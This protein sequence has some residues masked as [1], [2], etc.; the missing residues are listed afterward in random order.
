MHPVFSVFMIEMSRLW[1]RVR[2]PRGLTRTDISAL[3]VTQS[4]RRLAN[5]RVYTIPQIIE[6]QVNYNVYR[7]FKLHEKRASALL[8]ECWKV[9]SIPNCIVSQGP[10]RLGPRS[11]VIKLVRMN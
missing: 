3:S 7:A 4:G 6:T 9:S 2:Q 11:K 8:E 10:P 5:Y 1:L